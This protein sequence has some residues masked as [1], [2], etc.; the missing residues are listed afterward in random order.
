MN[1]KVVISLLI[2]IVLTVSYCI[3]AFAI[4]AET[5]EEHT[6]RYV[7]C[8]VSGQKHDMFGRGSGIVYINGKLVLKGYTTQ[9]IHCHDVIISEYNPNYWWTTKLGYYGYQSASEDVGIGTVMYT[10]ELYYN[11]SLATDPFFRA[12]VFH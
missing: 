6:L 9:C 11:D 3:P 2:L 12:F 4:Q 1:K 10:D 5:A 8:P 7:P